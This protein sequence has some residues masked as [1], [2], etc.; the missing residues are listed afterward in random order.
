MVEYSLDEVRAFRDALN[1]CM[2]HIEA[3]DPDGYTSTTDLR[4]KGCSIHF[5]WKSELPITGDVSTYAFQFV[6]ANP[7][8]IS[9]LLDQMV[10]L[11][12]AAD[13]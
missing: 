2:D 1:G 5:K 4:P 6:G 9:Q 8:L 11:M 3:A 12:E 13:V 10:G 7:A